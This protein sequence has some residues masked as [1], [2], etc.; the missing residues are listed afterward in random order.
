MFRRKPRE[1]FQSVI[2]IVLLGVEGRPT[3]DWSFF[4]YSKDFYNRRTDQRI[5]FTHFLIHLAH[6]GE[7]PRVGTCGWNTMAK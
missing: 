2:F 1:F 4:F 5:E 6:N 3:S 7:Q